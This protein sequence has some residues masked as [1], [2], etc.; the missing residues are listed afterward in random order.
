MLVEKELNWLAAQGIS[1]VSTVTQFENALTNDVFLITNLHSNA[2]IFKRL[3]RKARSDDDR[4]AEFL[5]QQIAFQQGL[6]PQVLAHSQDYKLQQ[7]I[8]GQLLAE[9]AQLSELLAEQLLRIH[10][11]PVLHA[12]QQ[13]LEFELQQLK[14]Q[15]PVSI[16]EIRFQRML[17]LATT[18]DS[19]SPRDTLCH[20]DLS[21]NN[22]L[23]GTDKQLYILDWEYAVIAGVAY[24]L[25]FCNCI[26]G[27]T[28]TQRNA[29]IES[30]YLQ[31]TYLAGNELQRHDSK[32]LTLK[33]LHKEC[34]LYFELFNY[35]NELWSLCFVE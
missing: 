2:F 24:D 16:D 30:Y 28:S 8:D 33:S 7:Y 10:Q 31:C 18:L 20:G 22:V 26:N 19:S 1:P 32:Q 34:E 15:L 14:S 3:N 13:R 21:V 35:I 12:P 6:T 29:L 9:T 25:A 11:L 4:E 23:C 17:A 27:F 5:V